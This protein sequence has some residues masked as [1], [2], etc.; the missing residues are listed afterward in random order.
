M[1]PVILRDTRQRYIILIEELL[2]T[3]IYSNTTS[4]INYQVYLE[5]IYLL[6]NLF[7]TQMFKDKNTPPG[8]DV[9]W[10]LL[11]NQMNHFANGLSTRLLRNYLDQQATPQDGQ[12]NGTHKNTLT[13][14]LFMSAFNFLAGK[15]TVDSQ[16]PIAD[17]SI[18]LLILLSSQNVK[19]SNHFYN[20]LGNFDA[21]SDPNYS[22]VAFQDT[23]ISFKL[24]YN[25]ISK[26]LE[27]YENI[28]LLYILLIRNEY[29]RMYFLSRT[30]PEEMVCN[31]RLLI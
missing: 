23:H 6:F 2:Q 7:S 31:K 20:M 26:S 17:I 21:S 5:C 18:N 13:I 24:I 28:V 8:L 9:F 12:E 11:L 30:D 3:M 15:S 19:S 1:D 4:F 16:T 29:F 14:G 22:P 25:Q 27:R 10:D